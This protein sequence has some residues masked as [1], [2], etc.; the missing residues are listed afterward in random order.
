LALVEWRDAVNEEE[1]ALLHASKG[2]NK[3]LKVILAVFM[4]FVISWIE[5]GGKYDS[6]IVAAT[7]IDVIID[8]TN[9]TPS[10]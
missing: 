3:C 5:Y 2:V 10:G 7:F 1:A 6:Q 8:V 4:I 9:S